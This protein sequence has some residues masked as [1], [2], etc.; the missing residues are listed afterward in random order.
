MK[1]RKHGFCPASAGRS[2]LSFRAAC[3]WS[4][5]S[6]RV[7]AAIPRHTLC[8][9]RLWLTPRIA[10]RRK[11]CSGCVRAL[12]G[13]AAIWRRQTNEIQNFQGSYWKTAEEEQQRALQQAQDALNAMTPEE[14]AKMRHL[15]MAWTRVAEMTVS[16]LVGCVIDKRGASK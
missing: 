6:T 10:T 9:A 1:F 14:V 3:A 4:Y 13:G 8:A 11:T 2:R 16:E 12:T 5:R 7:S 15:L